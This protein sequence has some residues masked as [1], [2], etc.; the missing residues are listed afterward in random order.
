MTKLSNSAVGDKGLFRS[1]I[2][3]RTLGGYFLSVLIIYY[4]YKTLIKII[5]RLSTIKFI[6]LVL[7]TLFCHFTQKWKRGIVGYENKT[8][9]KSLLMNIFIVFSFV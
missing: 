9:S 2:G 1:H 6:F 3:E 4:L 7:I 8:N 5:V